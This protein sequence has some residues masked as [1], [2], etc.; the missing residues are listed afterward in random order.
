MHMLGT[1]NNGGELNDTCC[2]VLCLTHEECLARGDDADIKPP[3]MHSYMRLYFACGRHQTGISTSCAAAT[4]L[5]IM[6]CLISECMKKRLT[7]V[8]VMRHKLQ[9]PHSNQ[10]TG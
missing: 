4:Y 9:D 8:I 6:S 5:D 3:P 10:K 1:K 2:S 7:K